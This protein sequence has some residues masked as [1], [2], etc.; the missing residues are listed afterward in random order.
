METNHGIKHGKHG[1]QSG[2]KPWKTNMENK[3]ESNHGKQTWKTNMKQT[4][5]NNNRASHHAV[6]IELD[7]TQQC[8]PCVILSF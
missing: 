2:I 7:G 5:E 3:Q 4:M 8:I 1:K 6:Q